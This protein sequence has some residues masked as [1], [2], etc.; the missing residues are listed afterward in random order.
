MPEKGRFLAAALAVT[1]AF[2]HLTQPVFAQDCISPEDTKF[3]KNTITLS[4][5][6]FRLPSG[7]RVVGGFERRP[8]IDGQRSDCLEGFSFWIKAGD[9]YF[10]PSM[11]ITT[12]GEIVDVQEEGQEGS[13]DALINSLPL[14][15]P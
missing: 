5:K 12:T 8:I 6:P 14:Q 10:A 7:Y 1:E 2:I 4:G 11:T 15:T 13:M 3:N 9:K